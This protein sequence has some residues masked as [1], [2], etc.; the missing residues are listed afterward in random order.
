[1][2]AA[3]E[4]LVARRTH[5]D[6]MAA[7]GRR[8]FEQMGHL[9]SLASRLAGAHS[10]EAVAE[11]VLDELHVAV[12]NE[13]S[14]VTI[15]EGRVVAA[16]GPVEGREALRLAAHD[17]FRDRRLALVDDL[18]TE[19]LRGAL[20]APLVAGDRAVGAIAIATSRP[21]SYDRDD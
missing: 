12:P 3:D 7:R 2:P 13:A 15:G 18:G 21:S 4:R 9:R 11:T 10:I 6:S 5:G 19:Q 14:L 16:R 8:S 20:A 1:M 17:A